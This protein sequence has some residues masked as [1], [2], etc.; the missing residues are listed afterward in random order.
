MLNL[1]R[2]PVGVEDDLELFHQVTN[3]FGSSPELKISFICEAKPGGSKCASP[4]QSVTVTRSIKRQE[5][6]LVRFYGQMALRLNLRERACSSP[7]IQKPHRDRKED[8]EGPPGSGAETNGQK[9]LKRRVI[10]KTA[11]KGCGLTGFKSRRRADAFRTCLN[12]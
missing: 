12:S 11:R 9:T 5:A 6:T 2:N 3:K 1:M 10:V 4:S 8:G 7:I